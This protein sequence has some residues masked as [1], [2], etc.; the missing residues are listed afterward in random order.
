NYLTD[1]ELKM[2]IDHGVSVTATPTVETQSAKADPLC[3]RV[4]K[5]GDQPSLGSDTEVF[6]AGDMFHTMRYALQFQHAI[7][8]R[9][10]INDNMPTEKLATLPR[11][12]LEWATVA[13]ARALQ[14][15]HKIG[16]ITPGKKADLVLLKVD[17]VNLQP[18]H[19]PLSSVVLFADRSN[20]DAVII[21]GQFVKKDGQLVMPI[22]QI[23]RKKKL[24]NTAVNKVFDSAGF[25]PAA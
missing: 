20:V 13:G 24:L 15:E 10:Q 11:E 2:L 21:D 5:F 3:G 14:M 1:D 19:D 9:E 18:I 23:D 6:V 22:D 25:E 16:S 17:D 4:K 8:C 7:D 12:A